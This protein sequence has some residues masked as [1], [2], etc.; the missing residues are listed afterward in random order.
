VLISGCLATIPFG[1]R[2]QVSVGESLPAPLHPCEASALDTFVLARD[3][4]VNSFSKKNSDFFS[5]FQLFINLRH[6]FEV[7]VNLCPQVPESW[8]SRSENQRVS[9]SKRAEKVRVQPRSFDRAYEAHDRTAAT[10]CRIRQPPQ[11]PMTDGVCWNFMP[12]RATM[13]LG[14]DMTRPAAPARPGVRFLGRGTS[15]PAK[16]ASIQSGT[17][18]LPAN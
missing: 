10:R 2:H 3:R 1:G 18:M 6:N 11:R 8:F 15:C 17:M 9:R 14:T 7:F 5:F 12:P 16:R 13:S 4:D